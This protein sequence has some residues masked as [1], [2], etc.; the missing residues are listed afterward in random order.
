MK[1]KDSAPPDD[2]AALD[3]QAG[4]AAAALESPDAAAAPPPEGAATPAALSTSAALAPLVSAGFK[5]LAPAWQVTAEESDA[6]ADAWAAVLDKYFPD[7][8][9]LR[10]GVEVNAL[11]LTLAIFGPRWT[12]PRKLADIKPAAAAPDGGQG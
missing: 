7:G 1:A 5:I 2:T 12:L 3:L 10:F 11:L 6:L 9:L 4:A 8:A